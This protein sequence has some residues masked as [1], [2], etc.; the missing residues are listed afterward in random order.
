MTWKKDLLNLPQVSVQLKFPNY[1]VN[2]GSGSMFLGKCCTRSYLFP[3]SRH[4]ATK[5]TNRFFSLLLLLLPLHTCPH[6]RTSPSFPPLSL[7]YLSYLLLPSLPPS[8]CCFFSRTAGLPDGEEKR[9]GE[10]E[11]KGEEEEEE[12]EEERADPDTT[13]ACLCLADGGAGG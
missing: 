4:A 2:P 12:E 3:S 9:E 13:T 7:L 1:L 6:F 10:K 5:A 11:R 8:C